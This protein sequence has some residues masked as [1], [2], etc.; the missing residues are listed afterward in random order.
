MYF[1]SRTET[2]M[3]SAIC[4]SECVICNCCMYYGMKSAICC[5]V[6]SVLCADYTAC[7]IEYE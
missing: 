1:F 4:D 5:K 2:Y 6:M 3:T 7:V